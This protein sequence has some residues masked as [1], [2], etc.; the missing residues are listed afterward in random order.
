MD[1]DYVFSDTDTAEIF[2][3]GDCDPVI[4]LASNQVHIL[5]NVLSNARFNRILTDEEQG[6]LSLLLSILV[7]A[8][9]QI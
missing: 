8:R 1:A 3:C 5:I 6:E 7:E 9:V 2:T 4:S